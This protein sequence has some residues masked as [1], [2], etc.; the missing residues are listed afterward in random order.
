[1]NTSLSLTTEKKWLPVNKNYIPIYINIWK[2]N[3]IIYII[4]YLRH[5]LNEVTRNLKRNILF[6]F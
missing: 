5:H 3:I 6:F 2:Y 4:L 1:M